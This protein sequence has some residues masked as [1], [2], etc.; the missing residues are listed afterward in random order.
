MKNV[1]DSKLALEIN[2]ERD[3]LVYFVITSQPLVPTTKFLR[4]LVRALLFIKLLIFP[5]G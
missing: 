1:K 3:N 5:E 2:N 4:R